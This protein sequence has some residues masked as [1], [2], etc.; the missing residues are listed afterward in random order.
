VTRQEAVSF[1]ILGYILAGCLLAIW[2]PL[3]GAVVPLPLF[4]AVW[5]PLVY[6]PLRGLWGRLT[7]A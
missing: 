6:M 4:L 5:G 1:G 7:H 3:I 2:F